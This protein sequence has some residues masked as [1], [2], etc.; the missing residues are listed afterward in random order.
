MH[1]PRLDHWWLLSLATTGD[2]IKEE[3]LQTTFSIDILLKLTT[4]LCSW[5]TALTM[6]REKITGWFRTVGVLAGVRIKLQSL[7]ISFVSFYSTNSL[8]PSAFCVPGENGYI[9]LKRVDPETLEDPDVDCGMDVT[10][11]TGEGCTKDKDG[12]TITPPAVKVCGTSG[13]LF[14]PVLPIGGKLV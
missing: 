10:P 11:R 7:V 1:S 12:H 2:T 3:Y 6:K 4:Q 14:D 13:I 5:A 9:R 8:I